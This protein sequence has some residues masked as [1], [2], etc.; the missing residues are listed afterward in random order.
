M[1]KFP[2]LFLPFRPHSVSLSL[3][4]SLSLYLSLFFR[5]DCRSYEIK[6]ALTVVAAAL[7]FHD[8]YCV[9]FKCAS[10]ARTGCELLKDN[11]DAAL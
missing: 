5:S 6:Y 4:L 8:G 11:L 1:E 9:R 2:P 7:K 3:S 10:I